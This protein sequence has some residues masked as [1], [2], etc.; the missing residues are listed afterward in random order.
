MST[1]SQGPSS[2]PN[3]LPDEVPL[4]SRIAAVLKQ[5]E[6]G[7]ITNR[8]AE[9]LLFDVAVQA[10]IEETL[11]RLGPEWHDR[12]FE[13]LRG[14]ATAAPDARPIKILGGIYRYEYESDPIEAARMRKEVEDADAA[15]EHHF[16]QVVRPLI[17]T[18]WEARQQR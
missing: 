8:E 4:D 7:M 16:M 17:R 6:D 13:I 9:G 14:W 3:T 1:D 2:A 11:A 12:V 18:W 5:W 10:G 15:D